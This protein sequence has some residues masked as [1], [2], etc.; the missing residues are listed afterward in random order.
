MQRRKLLALTGGSVSLA[1]A[2]CTDALSGDDGSEDEQEPNGA[3]EN[4]DGPDEQPDDGAGLELQIVASYPDPDNETEPVTEEVLSKEEFRSDAQAQEPSGAA[5]PR[6]AVS[7]TEA[8]AEQFA[9][10]M[11][12]T[13]FT[14][15]GRGNC[16]YDPETDESELDELPPDQHCLFTVLDGEILHGAAMGDLAELIDPRESGDYSDWVEDEA[17]FVIH[18]Q[19]QEEAEELAAV[20]RGEQSE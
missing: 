3:A 2:G 19:N 13:G 14:R 1:L 9:E 16:D 7:L 20:L 18:T 15:E 5:G 4:T 12:E 6:V 10:R 11:I 17:S 8:G